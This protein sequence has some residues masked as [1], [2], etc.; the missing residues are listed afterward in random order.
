[1]N[2]TPAAS[3]PA[4]ILHRTSRKGQQEGRVPPANANVVNGAPLSVV[5][6]RVGHWMLRAMAVRGR[7]RI[8]VARTTGC[9]GVLVARGIVGHGRGTGGR[10]KCE[11]SYSKR[12]CGFAEHDNSPCRNER[13]RVGGLKEIDTTAIRQAKRS[14]TEK[15]PNS[16]VASVMSRSDMSQREGSQALIAHPLKSTRARAPYCW[17]SPKRGLGNPTA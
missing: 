12:D 3:M 9:S 15:F 4:R 7:L 11:R 6:C 2:S 8:D 5:A 13:G 10:T 1:M 17:Q 16:D 14:P